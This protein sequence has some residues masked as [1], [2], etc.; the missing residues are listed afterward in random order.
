M[1]EDQLLELYRQQESLVFQKFEDIR[2]DLRAAMGRMASL[3][4]YPLL[5]VGD[6]AALIEMSRTL[7]HMEDSIERLVVERGNR[8]K[9]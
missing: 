1:S 6:T 2:H 3:K 9:L 5:T 4:N 7:K 8:H